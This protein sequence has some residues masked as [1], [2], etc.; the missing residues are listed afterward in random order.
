M[1]QFERLL[2]SDVEI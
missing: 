1:R 2:Q